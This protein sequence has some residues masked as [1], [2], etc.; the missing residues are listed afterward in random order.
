M[1]VKTGMIGKPRTTENGVD[2]K[3]RL[4]GGINVTDNIEIQSESIEGVYN[5]YGVTHTGDTWEGVFETRVKT[6]PIV[7]T[8]STITTQADPNNPNLAADAE[9]TA[10]TEQEAE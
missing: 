3:V 7:G 1:S 4:T 9:F 2:V 6:M 5:V 10:E 8:P